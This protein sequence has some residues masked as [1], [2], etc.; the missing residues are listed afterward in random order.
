MKECLSFKNILDIILRVTKKKAIILADMYLLKGVSI[1][2]KWNNNIVVPSSEDISN[3]VKFAVKESSE[4]QKRIIRDNIEKLIHNSSLTDDI[5]NEILKLESFS[6]F[7]YDTLNISTE[8]D[9]YKNE[10]MVKNKYPD[11]KDT[12]SDIVVNACQLTSE[13]LSGEYSGVVRFDLNLKRKGEDKINKEIMQKGRRLTA[14]ITKNLG[15][16]VMTIFVLGIFSSL[17]MDGIAYNSVADT[18]NL[19]SSSY[20][21]ESVISTPA[22]KPTEELKPEPEAVVKADTYQGE[23]NTESAALP[24]PSPVPVISE[25][26]HSPKKNTNKAAD[27]KEDQTIIKSIDGNNINVNGNDDVVISVSGSNN[28][29]SISK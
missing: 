29:V 9:Y 6:E 27:K 21:E 11:K 2:Y 7:L 26:S 8:M 16:S 28:A 17:F 25:K 20:H 15:K 4:V 1:I 13:N 5:K 23:K 18:T 22:P 10:V 14:N 12:V 3:I 19:K 24:T